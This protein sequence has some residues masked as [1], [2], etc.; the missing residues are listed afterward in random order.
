MYLK[1]YL[2]NRVDFAQ[3]SIWHPQS[4]YIDL[5]INVNRDL[6]FRAGI[7][8][9]TYGFMYIKHTIRPR[10]IWKRSEKIMASR[11]INLKPLK[12]SSADE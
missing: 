8:G 2:Q 7:K 5:Q 6:Q 3:S 9:L 4:T 1:W 12:H 10:A 11:L